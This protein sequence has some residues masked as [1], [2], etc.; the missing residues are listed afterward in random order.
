MKA[1]NSTVVFFKKAQ[2]VLFYFMV[3]GKEKKEKTP[4]F[5]HSQ[6]ASGDMWRKN[7]KY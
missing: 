5:S 3:V 7:S 4:P 1:L 6:Q 2:P